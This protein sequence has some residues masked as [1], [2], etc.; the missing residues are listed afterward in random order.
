MPSPKPAALVTGGAKGIGRAIAR[1]LVSSGWQI[2]VIDL[3]DSGLRRAYAR[4][5]GVFAMEGDVRD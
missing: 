3:A 1:N 2:A 5:R 4:E